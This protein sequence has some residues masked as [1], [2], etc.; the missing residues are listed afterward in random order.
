MLVA[1]GMSFYFIWVGVD[2]LVGRPQAWRVVLT[3]P[4][5]ALVVLYVFSALMGAPRA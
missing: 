3:V 1:L 5:L 2:E 4:I